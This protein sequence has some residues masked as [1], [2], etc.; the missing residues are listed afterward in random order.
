[1]HAPTQGLRC[2]LL[3]LLACGG[4]NA[5]ALNYSVPYV[6]Q[7]LS[8][9][10]VN[11]YGA[12]IGQIEVRNGDG[13]GI[14]GFDG[15]RHLALGPTTNLNN[16][17]YKDVKDFSSG[18]PATGNPADAQFHGTFVAG[19][20]ANNASIN[21]GNGTVIPFS[22]M[23]PGARY[24]GAIFDGADTQTAFLSLKNSLDYLTR[25]AGVSSI[26]NSWGSLATNA[27]QLDGNSAIAL[28]MDEYAG[29]QG[30]TSGTAGGYLDKLM[31]VAA[32]NS[33][34]L[35]GSPADAYNG[36]SVGALAVANPSA[37]GLND[38]TRVPTPQVAPYSARMPLAN[39]R[40]GV[41]LVA[42]GTALWSDLAINVAINDFGITNNAN[43][44]VAGVAAG[45]SFAAPHVTGEAALLYG[46]A[47]PLTNYLA[48]GVYVVT[49]PV[50]DKGAPLAADHKLIKAVI[51]N[52]ADKIAGL[53]T[54]GV[55]QASWQPGLITVAG[56]VTNAIVPLNY[57]VGAGQANAQEAVQTYQETGNRFWDL[58][59]VTN[60]GDAIAYTYGVGKFTNSAPF[61]PALTLTATLVWDRHVDFTVDTNTNS[62]EAG[63]TTKNLL[64]NL[65][66]IL[67]V[68]SAPGTWSDY[69][70]SA[71]SLDNLE[72]IYL[73]NFSVANDF[74][75]VVVGASLAESALGETYALAVSYLPIPEPGTAALLVAFGLLAYA[76][77][78]RIR[79]RGPDF[80]SAA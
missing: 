7:G 60:T 13:N 45:T 59:T 3:A 1:M 18:N 53:D 52:S 35:L 8:Y 51:I 40:A 37:S 16:Y 28:L 4:M 6:R 66:L 76:R 34:G 67:Q 63:T 48:P 20:M 64:S 78:Q 58:N 36:L 19:I 75:L 50:S 15:H 55:P 14:D 54:N 44:I 5:R 27:A 73:P 72:Q 65:D 42:P 61:C 23:A 26:N 39:G 30:K 57:A 25:T 11:G 10:Y 46:L 17:G 80:R 49:Q 21:L 31:V 43:A 56:G 22:G 71:G 79:A 24:Y 12:V 70:E 41:D 38:P 69:Y 68:E 62:S 74:R 2:A 9:Y 47:T 29:Y 32:G 33:G 77:H